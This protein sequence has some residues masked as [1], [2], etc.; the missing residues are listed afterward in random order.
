MWCNFNIMKAQSNTKSME[1]WSY[2]WS[3]ERCSLTENSRVYTIQ[4]SSYNLPKCQWISSIILNWLTR[5][6]LVKDQISK[7]NFQY[8]G[9]ISHRYATVQSAMQDQDIWN[10]L[11]QNIRD[12]FIQNTPQN[13]SIQKIWIHFTCL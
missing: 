12:A 2:Y 3:H 6:N 7:E 9:A 13:K 4:T 1:M 5:W 8:H 11:P 10:E